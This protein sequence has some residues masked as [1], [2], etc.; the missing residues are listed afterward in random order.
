MEFVAMKKI[1]LHNEDKFLSIP[2]TKSEIYVSEDLKLFEKQK[3]LNFIYAV[4][5]LKNTSLD[6]N[7]TND[8]KKDYE[9]E[10]KIYD[11]MLKNLNQDSEEFLGEKF[12]PL[13]K[14]IIKFVLANLDPNSKSIVT[15]DKLADNIF[16]YLNSLL[17]YD[18]TPFIYPLYGSS[19]FSQA[20]S[21]MSSVFGSIFIV[22]DA[23]NVQVY[24][25]NE[26]FLD[27]Y[28]K[29]F[30]LNI[31]DSSKFKKF[32]SYILKILLHTEINC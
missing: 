32:F 29:K 11:D 6:V 19:E 9:V 21:R 15:V 27:P 16:K 28:N 17:V 4:M 1:F 30:I 14:N 22:S 7:T 2:C 31:H 12:T 25:N 18:V 8:I 10:N 26:M 20:L 24:N 3:L 13:L 23:L 5:K